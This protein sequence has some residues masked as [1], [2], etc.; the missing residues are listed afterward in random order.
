MT[1][2]PS[3]IPSNT[4]MDAVV[5]S[6]SPPTFLDNIALKASVQA[7]G[8]HFG[9]KQ[10]KRSK[11]TVNGKKRS[12][13]GYNLF[14]HMVREDVLLFQDKKEV[15]SSGSNVDNQ[16]SILFSKKMM[17]Y[18]NPKRIEDAAHRLRNKPKRKHVKKHFP[19]SFHELTQIVCMEWKLL[20]PSVRQMFITQ[21]IAET[22]Y[23]NS[24]QTPIVNKQQ[25]QYP[26]K[27]GS[28]G[29]IETKLTGTTSNDLKK[30]E[31]NNKI[32][33]VKSNANL[34]QKRVQPPPQPDLK[35]QHTELQSQRKASQHQQLQSM[36]LS[37][38]DLKR[39]NKDSRNEYKLKSIKSNEIMHKF[40]SEI[41]HPIKNNTILV[42]G[43]VLTNNQ[44]VVNKQEQNT[45][46][47]ASHNNKCCFEGNVDTNIIQRINSSS[48][49][50]TTSIDQSLLYYGNVFGDYT[51][52]P[53]S[54]D[55]EAS[56]NP[57]LEHKLELE[58]NF[59]HRMDDVMSQNMEVNHDEHNQTNS[60]KPLYDDSIVKETH[61]T[62]IDHVMMFDYC[63]PNSYQYSNEKI[64][65]SDTSSNNNN[66]RI[67]NNNDI[68]V[69]TNFAIQHNNMMK[70][71]NQ[72]QG[73]V[74][75][76]FSRRNINNGGDII[77]TNNKNNK[78]QSFNVT[79]SQQHPSLHHIQKM[80]KM[81]LFV[82]NEQDMMI[83]LHQN[84]HLVLDD[85]NTS[86]SLPSVVENNKGNNHYHSQQHNKITTE[87][88]NKHLS[89][90]L[91]DLSSFDDF[92][93]C[94]ME[95]NLIHFMQQHDENDTIERVSL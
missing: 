72:R 21:A 5:I 76:Y 23:Y 52:N 83:R 25:E 11:Q 66:E 29:V 31:S 90:L 18:F 80:H 77:G 36:Q 58:Y 57:I 49:S 8:N 85:I 28:L 70:E 82:Q 68:Y 6:A 22:E 89:D 55:L 87:N 62:S 65:P 54:E 39:N 16:H 45:A 30:K 69:D 59:Q 86:Y 38:I 34:H 27:T 79:S 9:V 95:P 19:I 64:I 47:L 63:E 15:S 60:M 14:F 67:H 93:S 48:N 51:F 91:Y 74:D 17:D 56:M 53:I 32:M 75:P 20:I 37:C 24:Q 84:K 44:V 33:S 78:H 4:I 40:E 42:E 1:Q 13:S 3:I 26:M 94:N 2:S 41:S 7:L 50:N 88:L 61:R 10:F 46:S 73:L 43:S 35:V 12:P 81:Q 71:H 92:D